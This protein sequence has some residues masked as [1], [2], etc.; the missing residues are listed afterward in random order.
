[1]DLCTAG[2]LLQKRHTIQQQATLHAVACAVILLALSSGR[3]RV[4]CDLYQQL[5]TSGLDLEP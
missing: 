5:P 4:P 1:M 3:R 2:V